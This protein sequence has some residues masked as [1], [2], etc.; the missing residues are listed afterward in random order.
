MDWRTLVLTLLVPLLLICGCG[1]PKPPEIVPVTGSL[2][3]KGKPLSKAKV[4]F[5]PMADGLG[6]NFTAS[7]V[8][9]EEGKFSLSLPGDKGEG[10]YACETKV[11][12]VEGP[13]PPGSRDDS[14]KGDEIR[15][16]HRASLKN[17]PIPKKYAQ[18]GTTPFTFT[19]SAEENHFDLELDNSK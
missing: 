19:V 1:A 8:T 6:G 15:R 17:R 5:L 10:C 14:E 3:Y 13:S 11:I 12:V 9:D 7:G 4:R 18:I 16:K 2:T